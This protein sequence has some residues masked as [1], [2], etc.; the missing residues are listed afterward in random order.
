MSLTCSVLRKNAVCRG[1]NSKK[2]HTCQSV[3][4]ITPSWW[5]RGVFLFL[6]WLC[7]S[8]PLPPLNKYY[9]CNTEKAKVTFKTCRSLSDAS[10]TRGLEDAERLALTLTLPKSRLDELLGPGCGGSSSLDC[11]A[12]LLLPSPDPTTLLKQEARPQTPPEGLTSLLKLQCVHYTE[13]Q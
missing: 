10:F 5:L 9:L 11:A 13:I 12:P 3:S 7:C 1:C 8:L 6:C 4:D 2:E